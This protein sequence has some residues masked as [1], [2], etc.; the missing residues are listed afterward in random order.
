MRLYDSLTR[1]VHEVKPVDGHTVKT[2]HKRRFKFTVHTHSMSA[3][4]HRL[5]ATVVDRFG[6]RATRKRTFVRCAG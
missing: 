4:K 6:R 1:D 5:L 2:A 3:G